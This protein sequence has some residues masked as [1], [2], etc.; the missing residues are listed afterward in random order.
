MLDLS[1]CWRTEASAVAVFS[2]RTRRTLFL[3]V[4]TLSIAVRAARTGL[5]VPARA[6]RTVV[7]GWAYLALARLGTPVAL[8]AEVAGDG[9]RVVDL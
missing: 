3:L 8:W 6:R 1:T 9:V 5:P 7:T 4:Q 2:G